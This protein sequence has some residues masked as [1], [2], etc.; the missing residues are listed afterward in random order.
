MPEKDLFRQMVA[1]ILPGSPVVGRPGHTD[2]SGASLDLRMR[3]S[4]AARG[5]PAARA[6]A[7]FERRNPAIEAATGSALRKG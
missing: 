6:V 2:Q 1:T 5:K 4:C 3:A 7:G